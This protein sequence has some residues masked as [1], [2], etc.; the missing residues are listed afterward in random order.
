MSASW[1]ELAENLDQAYTAFIE[2]ASQL[3]ADLHNEAG[4]CGEWSPR[5]VAAHLVGWDAE[6]VRA[7]R[8]F[9][10]GDGDK[11]I[12]PQVDEFNA[13]S[14][15]SRQAL[16]WNETLNELQTTQHDLQEMIQV[17]AAQGL[18]PAG[19][20]GGWLVGRKD[21]YEYHTPQLQAWVRTS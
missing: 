8:L 20:F 12:P 7:F 17:V 4:V 6:A 16:T 2:V 3:D 15:S 10:N 14:V 11:F 9:A 21:D 18:N 19:G 1:T 5:E 13:Q